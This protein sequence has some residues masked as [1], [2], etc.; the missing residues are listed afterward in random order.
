MRSMLLELKEPKGNPSQTRMPLEGR[1]AASFCLGSGCSSALSLDEDREGNN[2]QAFTTHDGVAMTLGSQVR[3]KPVTKAGIGIAFL[4]SQLGCEQKEEWVFHQ[5]RKRLSWRQNSLCIWRSFTAVLVSSH[6][7]TLRRPSPVVPKSPSQSNVN[8]RPVT[9][10][11]GGGSNP[12]ES[13]VFLLLFLHL[14]TLH[15]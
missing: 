2:K 1:L 13:C 10:W 5:T 9:A 6:M 3:W 8:L 11:E 14:S 7:C 15:Q 12:L 4:Y